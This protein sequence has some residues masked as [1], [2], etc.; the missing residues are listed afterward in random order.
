MMKSKL[1]NKKVIINNSLDYKK[2]YNLRKKNNKNNKFNT[3]K[4]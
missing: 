4:I 3:K 2:M 1:I